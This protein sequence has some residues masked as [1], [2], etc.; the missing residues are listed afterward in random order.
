MAQSERQ[1]ENKRANKR[2]QAREARSRRAASSAGA[3]W[4]QF[5]W[6]SMIALIKALTAQDGAVR[7]GKTRDGGAWAFGIYSGDDYA[8]E[9]VRPAEDFAAA[10]EEIARAWCEDGGAFF[11]DT[12]IALRSDLAR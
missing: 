11:M 8:T 1:A 5:D 6:L 9:Y 4:E 3:D 7:V 10:V 12:L 2:E